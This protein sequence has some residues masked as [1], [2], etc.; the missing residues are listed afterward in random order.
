MTSSTL[1]RS[2]PTKMWRVLNCFVLCVLI[3]VS[4]EVPLPIDLTRDITGTKTEVVN[5]NPIDKTERFSETYQNNDMFETLAGSPNNAFDLHED[6]GVGLRRKRA[7]MP[8]SD[9]GY[10]SRLLA[11][12][13][14]AHD[15]SIFGDV[16]GKYGPGKR[17]FDFQLRDKKQ[18]TDHGYGSRVDAGSNMA[19]SLWTKENIFGRSGPGKRSN[20][21]RL[22]SFEHFG[23]PHNNFVT[24]SGYGSRID[25]GSTLARDFVAE[26]DLFGRFGPGRRKRNKELLETDTQG[27]TPKVVVL[28]EDDDQ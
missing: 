10:G 18:L 17:A 23:R 19:N 2:L 14:M 25:T 26:G 13:N 27:E 5:E 9:H 1:T 8:M 16:F 4:T 20:L 21:W 6:D 15:M 7:A 24:D 12:Q 11:G 3:N 28:V 22:N